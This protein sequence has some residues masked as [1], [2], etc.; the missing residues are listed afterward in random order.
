MASAI[1]I[2]EAPKAAFGMN[3]FW[4]ILR[5]YIW[6]THKRGSV[7]YDVMVTLILL[8]VFIAP[9]KI[10]FDDKPAERIPHPTGIVAYPDGEHGLVFEVASSAVSSK[11]PDAVKADLLRAIAPY[12]G[13][14][15]MVRYEAIKDRGKVS[16]Y[17]VWI[18]RR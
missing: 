4:Q 10:D 9:F 1:T 2:E 14:V 12:A 16:L 17:R 11:E 3:K 5:S 18:H 8:F 6:W 13:N 7:H 15:E